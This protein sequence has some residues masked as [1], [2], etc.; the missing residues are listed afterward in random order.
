[1][2][3][4]VFGRGGAPVS[5]RQFALR[6]E[7]RSYELGWIPRSIRGRS[8]FSELTERPEFAV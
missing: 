4:I 3:N 1:M 2:I 8:D 6:E 7:R 5:H